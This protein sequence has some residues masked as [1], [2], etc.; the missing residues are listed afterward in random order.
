[1]WASISKAIG[2][3]SQ[4]DSDD[5][6]QEEED[7]D[8]EQELYLEE[9]IL[10]QEWRNGKVTRIEDDFYLIDDRFYWPTDLSA[11]IVS[12]PGGRIRLEDEV[13]F[14]VVKQSEN[15]DWKVAEVE[16]VSQPCKEG[17]GRGQFYFQ[18]KM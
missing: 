12:R 7:S 5:P 10:A 13:R 8:L 3:D 6:S 11:K 4:Q 18:F 17:E 2:L 15:T 14:K 1:M 16:R 9:E